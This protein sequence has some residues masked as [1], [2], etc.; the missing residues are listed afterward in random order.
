V[1]DLPVKAQQF[2]SLMSLDTSDLTLLL[3]EKDPNGSF[4][5]SFEGKLRATYAR[6]EN[7]IYFI[8]RVGIGTSI[9]E[10]T[11]FYLDSTE[12]DTRAIGE[13]FIKKHGL[14]AVSNYATLS[15]YEGK[16]EEVVCEIVAAYGRRGQF[17]KIKELFASTMAHKRH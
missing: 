17:E 7:R 1:V 12:H 16:W 11:H 2:I 13:A 4:F 8:E 10:L 9:H 6:F 14:E 3:L 5:M 15:Y